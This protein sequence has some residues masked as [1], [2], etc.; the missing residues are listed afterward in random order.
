MSSAKAAAGKAAEK[1]KKSRT[2][3]AAG[4]GALGG[5][6][7][8]NLTG[9]VSGE[10]KG[11]KEADSKY[12]MSKKAATLPAKSQY[13]NAG[14]TGKTYQAKGNFAKDLKGKA[15][16]LAGKMPSGRQLKSGAGLAAGAAA[17]GYAA[18]KVSEAIQKPNASK[19]REASNDRLMGKINKA[20]KK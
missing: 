4:I 11:R 14:R 18:H 20:N 3:K 17:G 6:Y 10:V 19:R 7:A 13:A 8:G 9:A 15:K 5:A 16:A 1:V 2:A 12:T